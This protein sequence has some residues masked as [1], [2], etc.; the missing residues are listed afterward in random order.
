MTTPASRTLGGVHILVVDDEADIRLGLTRLLERLG[1]DVR[2]ARDGAEAL[3]MFDAEPADVVVT[4]LM[5]PRMSGTELLTEVK[6]RS[7][8][9]QVVIVTGFGTIQTAVQSLRSG[10]AHFLTKPFDNDEVVQVVERL[11]LQV[12]AARAAQHRDVPRG[13]PLIG[14]DPAMLR[15]M[16]L[17]DRAARSPVPVLVEGESGTGKELVARA[18]HARSSVASRPFLAVNA[19]ALPDTLLE[20]E[21]FGHRRGAFTGA[22]RDRE[23][24]FVA[25]RGGTVFLDEVSSMSQSFQG[26]LLRVLQDHV[27]RPLGG[28]ADVAVEFRLV[29]ATNR[30]L[31][32]MIRRGEF[33]EDL[34]YRLGV[35]RVFIPPLRERPRDV[36]PLARHFLA[37]AAKA[38]L[39]PGAAEPVLSDD[40]LGA[41]KAHRW[42]GN[43]RELANTLQRA[44]VVSPGDRILPHHLGLRDSGWDSAPAGAADDGDADYN[45]EKQRA[46]E[47]FQREY[48]Q[49]ALERAKGNISHA[50][51]R[52]GL[53]R[54]ALQRI[55]RQLGIERTHFD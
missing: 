33:R 37:E 44:V 29:C 49:R 8:T 36:E 30:D 47:R 51:E 32:P 9:T 28:A 2:A 45:A 27:V 34:F 26:K 48:V 46:I 7:R 40:A 25:A 4:D 42:P 22:D 21:L 17:V 12:L 23:G 38:C 11:G 1:A 20:S 15:V 6:T 10:A 16:D 55:M 41:L 5:M 24:L 14:I 13:A 43:V 54:A 53:T 18:I 35:V 39:P 52:C 3:R 50:A 19:A 31:E